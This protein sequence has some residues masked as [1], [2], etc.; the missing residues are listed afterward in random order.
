MPPW[1]LNWWLSKQENSLFFENMYKADARAELIESLFY[2]M[3]LAFTKWEQIH[4]FGVHVLFLPR[5][6]NLEHHLVP[7]SHPSYPLDYFLCWAGGKKIWWK[8]LPSVSSPPRCNMVGSVW[9]S[10]SPRSKF[11]KRIQCRVSVEEASWPKSAKGKQWYGS[12]PEWIYLIQ[13]S[14]TWIVQFEDSYHWKSN[15]FGSSSAGSSK[16]MTTGAKPIVGKWTAKVSGR[17]CESPARGDGREDG[18]FPPTLLPVWPWWDYG[19]CN[20]IVHF[21]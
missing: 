6:C 5:A 4:G 1:K 9:K 8:T 11:Y 3:V 18:I 19:R 12:E 17:C 20:R 13:P 16:E 14:V 15:I 10:Q 2:F 7:G 21:L